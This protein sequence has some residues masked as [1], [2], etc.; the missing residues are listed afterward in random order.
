MLQCTTRLEPAGSRPSASDHPRRFEKLQTL[1]GEVEQ[2]AI[3]LCVV[4]T[5]ARRRRA[6]HPRG[7]CR[8]PGK[9][10]LHLEPAE[11]FGLHLDNRVAGLSPIETPFR[12][13]GR[14]GSPTISLSAVATSASRRANRLRRSRQIF[15][16][17][18][19][20]P[21]DQPCTICRSIG[22]SVRFDPFDVEA[23]LEGDRAFYAINFRL[24]LLSQQVEG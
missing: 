17:N 15:S 23:F 4:L 19:F 1:C 14:S 2:L 21:S 7:R 12:L 16:T 11:A 10:A 8:K 18:W 20:R 22:A 9:R 5:D 6:A 24:F 13:G 3:I